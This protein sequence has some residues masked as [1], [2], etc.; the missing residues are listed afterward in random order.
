MYAE[1]FGDT[2]DV[3]D[4]ELVEVALVFHAAHCRLAEVEFRSELA[5]R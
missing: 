1:D 2:A 3:A 5:S 4:R